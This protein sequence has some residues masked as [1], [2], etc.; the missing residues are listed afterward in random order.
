VDLFGHLD[1]D[2]ENL[3]G[4][5]ALCESEEQETLLPPDVTG[6]IHLG[7]TFVRHKPLPPSENSVAGRR[8][9]VP[10]VERLSRVSPAREHS[11]P[12]LD[13]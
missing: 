2:D 9:I 1:G 13:H 10:H 4:R 5:Q 6:G 8:D 7:V 12:Q 3:L 11:P